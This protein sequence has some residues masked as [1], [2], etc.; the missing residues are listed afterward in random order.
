MRTLIDNLPDIVFIKDAQSRFTMLNMACAQQLGASRPEDIL[1]KS[2]ADFVAADLA[3]QYR[4]DEQSLMQ[5]GKP[6]HKEE[7]TQFKETGEMHW[8]LTSKIPMKHEDGRII[9]LIGIARDI[10]AHKHAE[11]ALVQERTLLRTLIDNLPDCIYAKDATGRKILANP[12]DLEISTARPRLR[13]SARAISI[14]FRRKSLK[15]SGPTTSG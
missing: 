12:A 4:A 9:G 14:S 5:S 3:A 7:P 15:N 1:G 6:V 8:S 13:P 10:T 11:Q 2:D